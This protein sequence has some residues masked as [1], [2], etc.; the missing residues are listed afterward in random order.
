[1]GTCPIGVTKPKPYPLIT[2]E[3]AILPLGICLSIS[4]WGG[5]ACRYMYRDVF[6]CVVCIKNIESETKWP[7]K[8]N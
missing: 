3:G 2:F 7:F 1:M 6:K 4:G 8:G 5:G